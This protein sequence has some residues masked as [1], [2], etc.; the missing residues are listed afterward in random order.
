MASW[1]LVAVLPHL[2]IHLLFLPMPH[3][4][5]IDDDKMVASG[6]S[7]LLTQDNQVHIAHNMPEMVRLLGKHP[8]DVA[9]LDIHMHDTEPDLKFLDVLLAK[10]IPVLAL[11]GTASDVEILDYLRKGAAGIIRKTDEIQEMHRGIEAL[12]GGKNWIS[13]EITEIMQRAAGKRVLSRREQDILDYF[14]LDD[15]P[16]NKKIARAEGISF[17]TARNYVSDLLAACDAKSRHQLKYQARLLGYA[18]SGRKLYIEK[19]E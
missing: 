17:S 19:E 4:L 8:I 16:S 9:V 14:F 15:V 11:T 6:L 1:Q 2:P 18:P 5:L 10:N 3:I 7:S 13:L 12:L